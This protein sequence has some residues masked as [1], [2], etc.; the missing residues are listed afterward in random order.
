MKIEKVNIFSALLPF[1]EDFS[2]SKKKGAYANNVIVEVI[3]DGK[4]IR[5][6]G[7]GA[8]REYVTGETIESVFE[9]IQDFL[10]KDSFPWKLHDLSQVWDFVDSLPNKKDHNAAICALEMSLLDVL[11]KKQ[12]KYIMD[13]F[14]K[15][16]LTDTVQYGAAIPL[17]DKRR[18]TQICRLIKGM[19]IKRLKLKIGMNISQNKEIFEAVG[20][21]FGDDCDIKI[22]ANGAWDYELALKHIPLIRGHKVRVVE[23]PLMSGDTD[24]GK[25]AEIL[26]AHGVKLMADES[27]CSLEEVERIVEKGHYDMIN[28]RLSK[29]GG[30]R[31]SLKMIDYLRENALNFQIGSHL[32]ESGVLSAANR[33]LCLLC[34]D[35][36][37]YDCCYDEF[38][39]KENTTVENVSFGIGGEAGSL[40][41]AGLG[42]NVS[43][44]KL[45][46]LCDDSSTVTIARP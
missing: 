5:G 22:D 36:V 21:V 7:E 23:Q 34:G 43:S 28:V 19:K 20:L 31:R 46:R 4:R 17:A 29:C 42:V 9:S 40:N 15:N 25:F 37:Y 2:H 26:K 24:I 16:H 44:D 11:G 27:A 10:K 8:P 18:T 3:G 41:G 33:A 1:K 12:N 30:I 14:P 39:L 45:K 6:H 13:F 32:G 38:L 35:A